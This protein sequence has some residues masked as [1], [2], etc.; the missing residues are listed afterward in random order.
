MRLQAELSER[1][2]PSTRIMASL[3]G[4][5]DLPWSPVLTG[6]SLGIDVSEVALNVRSP[7]R[8]PRSAR[9]S[10]KK[11][12]KPRRPVASNDG[13]EVDVVYENDQLGLARP[14]FQSIEDTVITVDV[15]REHTVSACDLVN[16][17]AADVFPGMPWDA[18]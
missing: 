18:E 14:E 17:P 15:D 4:D 1:Q 5:D 11:S 6:T 3:L 12:A 9:K 7:P 16:E 13:D 2:D 10:R 8:S